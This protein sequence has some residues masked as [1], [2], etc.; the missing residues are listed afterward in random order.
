MADYSATKHHFEQNSLHF[1]TFHAKSEKSINAVIRHLPGDTP[2]ED[3]SNELVALGFS[4]I[5]VRQMTVNRQ[6]PQGGTQ[7]VNLPLFLVTLARSKKSKEI[8]KLNNLSNIMMKMEAYRAQTVSRSVTIAKRSATS[9]PNASK[10]LA[11]CGVEAV[12]CMK[13]APSRPMKIQH[14]TAATVP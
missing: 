6:L 1:H 3:I 13:S 4:V 14:Q 8:L 7:I 2:A 9:G 10:R 5:S 12:T 11:V